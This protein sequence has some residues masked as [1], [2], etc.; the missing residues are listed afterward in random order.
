MKEYEAGTVSGN[1]LTC[2]LAPP[3]LIPTPPFPSTVFPATMFIWHG[4]SSEA[5]ERTR[6]GRT[7]ESEGGECTAREKKH[8]Q[9]M[10]PSE[11]RGLGDRDQ[12]SVGEGGGG[13]TD[14]NAISRAA[15]HTV[16]E[17]EIVARRVRKQYAFAVAPGDFVVPDGGGLCLLVDLHYCRSGARHG[18]A[19]DHGA[20]GCVQPDRTGRRSA[21][22]CGVR[23]FV[24]LPL[25]DV[26][27]AV[28]GGGLRGDSTDGTMLPVLNVDRLVPRNRRP[29]RNENGWRERTLPAA[30]ARHSDR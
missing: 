25:P 7:K 18:V 23:Y 6:P 27:D 4:P 21:D 2:Q 22:E 24:P 9:H 8:G 28:R 3:A 1:P 11:P 15:A 13:R 14:R 26:D 17:D 19:V 20:D 5:S 10:N 30:P 16:T 29:M 12:D